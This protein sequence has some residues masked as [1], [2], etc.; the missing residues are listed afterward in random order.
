MLMIKVKHFLLTGRDFPEETTDTYD[1]LA[2]PWMCYFH[3]G[4]L[5]VVLREEMP[6]ENRMTFGDSLSI[7]WCS[8]TQNEND[9]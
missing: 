1:P 5:V 9:Y 3:S 4:R 7:I 2:R 8:S 6:A